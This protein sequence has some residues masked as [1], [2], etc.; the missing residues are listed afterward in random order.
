M[1]RDPARNALYARLE[2]VLGPEHAVTFM[3][4]L[5]PDRDELSTKQDVVALG[6]RLDHRIDLL[7]QRFDG[8]DH[9][10]DNLEQRMDRFEQRMDRFEDRMFGLE[11]KFDDR[12]H[13]FHNL[14]RDQ[15]RTFTLSMVGTVVAV[16]GLTTVVASLV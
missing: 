12:M 9:R 5:P 3:T 16:G 14:L 4:V 10:F 1:T 13:E 15:A 2:E 7:D 6:V 8:L 11:G